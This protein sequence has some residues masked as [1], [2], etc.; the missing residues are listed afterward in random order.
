MWQR[1]LLANDN[2]SSEDF[3][4]AL[5]ETILQEPSELFNGN[6]LI[7]EIA[8]QLCFELAYGTPS[9]WRYEG[10]A[11]LCEVYSTTH[12]SQ[13]IRNMGRNGSLIGDLATTT[14]TT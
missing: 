9:P 11:V 14:I 6:A 2:F 8:A 13:N 7:A 3:A 4:G 1:F 12:G 10:Y 5:R